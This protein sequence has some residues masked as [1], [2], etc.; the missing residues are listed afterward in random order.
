MQALPSCTP[1]ECPP[2]GESISL[3]AVL[4]KLKVDALAR[5]LHAAKQ[6]KTSAATDR[7]KLKAAFNRYLQSGEQ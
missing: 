2:S 4:D 1:M 7:S 6:I 5:L 3:E